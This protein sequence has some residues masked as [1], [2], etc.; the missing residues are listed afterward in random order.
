MKEDG[1]GDGGDGDMAVGTV[2]GWICG[3]SYVDGFAGIGGGIDK[4]VTMETDGVGGE[5]DHR[6][7]PRYVGSDG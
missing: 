2:G 4:V 6:A 5:L 1:E 3:E 7:L